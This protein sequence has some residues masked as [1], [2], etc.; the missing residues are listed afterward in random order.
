MT[1]PHDRI[2]LARIGEI[3]LKGLNRGDFEARLVSNLLRRLK[4]LGEI[5]AIRSQSVVRLEPVDAD[6]FDFEEAIRRIPYVFGLTSVSPARSFRGGIEEMRLQAADHFAPL[7]A[8]GRRR[9]FKIEARRSDKRFPLDSPAICRE[10]GA[11]LLETYP[12]QLSV[13][14]HHP[15]IALRIEVRD[16]ILLFDRI[17]KGHRGLPVG[18]AGKAVL[19]LSGGIDSPV[20]G[21][22]M[23]SRGLELECVHFQSIPFTSE[24]ALQKV[25]D[26]AGKLSLYAGRIHLHIVPFAGVQTMLRD[27]AP[28]DM[29]TLLMRRAMMR[30]AE[31]IARDHHCQAIITGESLGQVASQ[32]L[33]AIAVT[34]IVVGMPVFRP[35]AGLDKDAT[36]EIA[37]R[38]DTFE[39]SIEPYEDCCTV[40]VSKHPKTKPSLPYV[41]RLEA[42]LPLEE[43]IETALRGVETRRVG[44]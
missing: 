36:I 23:A 8:D 43:A 13:D 19:L 30:I 39:T 44:G 15:D 18:T 11:H 14:V 4:G 28:E 7:L 35:L 34:D 10:V 9:T 37:R 41:E 6:S 42:R 3:S 20:A 26:L 16:T 38:I 27:G 22:M 24:R 40:F 33:E 1:V 32:T 12:D 21:Y 5:V 31:R 17:I 2:L 29:L 25:V